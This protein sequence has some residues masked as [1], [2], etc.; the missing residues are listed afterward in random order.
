MKMKAQSFLLVFF[1]LLS[2]TAGGLSL[3]FGH[4]EAMLA[5]LLLSIAISV[6][7][8]IELVRELRPQN[9]K[10]KST[11]EDDDILPQVISAAGK[12]AQRRLFFVALG[13]LGGF[14]L[15]IYV[16]GFFLSTA[17]FSFSYLRSRR[18]SWASCSVFAVC[19]T[20]ALY[21]VFEMGFRSQLYRGLIFGG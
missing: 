19:F 3:T 2:V 21:L 8:L 1:L 14:V 20:A 11:E 13:W 18:N 15:G 12:G 4:Y 10:L 17:F 7:C 6:L 9:Q 16:F 5:P